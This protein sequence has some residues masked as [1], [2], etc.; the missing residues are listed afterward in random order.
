MEFKVGDR[1]ALSGIRDERSGPPFIYEWEE[2]VGIV[3]YVGLDVNVKCLKHGEY[4]CFYYS[5]KELKHASSSK[6]NLTG[7]VIL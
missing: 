6:I 4:T 5:P 7:K 1:V 2:E 3:Q